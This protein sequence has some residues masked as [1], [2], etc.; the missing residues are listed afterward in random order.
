MKIYLTLLATILI[1]TSIAQTIQLSGTVMDEETL[2][3]VRAAHIYTTHGE[4]LTSDLDGNFHIGVDLGDTLFFRHLSYETM[5]ITVT[6]TAAVQSI[7][8]ML[9]PKTVELDDVEVE[10]EREPTESII[11]LPEEEAVKMH[12]ITYPEREYEPNYRLGVV[13]AA[14]HPATAIYRLT[15]KKYKEEK[16]NHL[17]SK[18]RA[19]EQKTYSKARDN[20]YEAIKLLETDFDEYYMVDFLQ[21]MGYTVDDA[22]A[23]GASYYLY[24][25]IPKYLDRYYEQMK[26]EED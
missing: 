26:D 18:E 8:V 24:I 12:G 7:M 9:K 4:S 5:F 25:D 17:E 14:F 6:D 21:F 23:V 2:E 10:G 16:R 20:F 19:I 3:N 15:S 22:S 1:R 13:G 11:A